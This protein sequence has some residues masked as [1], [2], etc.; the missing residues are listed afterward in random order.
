MSWIEIFEYVV[1]NVIF[2]T[3]MALL[4]ALGV[5]VNREMKR[6]DRERKAK[7]TQPLK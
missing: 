3:L 1:I 6:I 7:E 5:D 4:I 2:L